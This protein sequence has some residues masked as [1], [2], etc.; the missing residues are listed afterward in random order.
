METDNGIERYLQTITITNQSMNPSFKNKHV[1]LATALKHRVT[2]NGREAEESNTFEYVEISDSGVS[3]GPLRKNLGTL[4]L[5]VI[6][7]S[8]YEALDMKR[9]YGEPLDPSFPHTVDAHTSQ[10]VVGE[11]PK[12]RDS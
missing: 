7:S 12:C 6:N 11:T 1:F 10:L 4:T 5:C 9:S 3:K 8:K 2:L